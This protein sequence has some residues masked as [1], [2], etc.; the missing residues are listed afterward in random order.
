MNTKSSIPRRLVKARQTARQTK[1]HGKKLGNTRRRFRKKSNAMPASIGEAIT[2][3][4]LFAQRR[5]PGSLLVVHR[6]GV[7]RV[8]LVRH[9]WREPGVQG[10][11]RIIR[12]FTAGQQSAGA[13]QDQ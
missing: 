8:D 9:G 6:G 13:N 11:A 5:L 7:R 10:S 12:R 3:D 4:R 2:N 1:R